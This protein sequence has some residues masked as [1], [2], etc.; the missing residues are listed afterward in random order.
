M[1][2]IIG[3]INAV[4][5]QRDTLNVILMKGMQNLPGCLSYIVALDPSFIVPNTFLNRIPKPIILL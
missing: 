2:G 3:K 5:G 4:P 1:C